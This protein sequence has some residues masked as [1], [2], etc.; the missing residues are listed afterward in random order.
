MSDLISLPRS[1]QTRFDFSYPFRQGLLFVRRQGEFWDA[2]GKG[3]Q[4]FWKDEDWKRAVESEYMNAPFNP[5]T[6]K[7]TKWTGGNMAQRE[8]LFY[9]RLIDK[10]PAP[11]RKVFDASEEAATIFI[12]KL[13][14]DVTNNVA[15]KW[16]RE[17]LSPTDP[18]FIQDLN[19]FGNYV[20]RATGYGNLGDLEKSVGLLNTV[21][22]GARRNISMVQAPGYLFN[23][24]AR[25]RVEAWKDFMGLFGMGAST[26]ALAKL[27]GIGDVNTF[28]PDSADWGKLKIGN[29]RLDIWGGYQQLARTVYKMADGEYKNGPNFQDF[30]KNALPF[31]GNKLSPQAGAAVSTLPEGVRRPI[32]PVDR[33]FK[34][35]D[36]LA[37]LAWQGLVQAVKEDGAVAGAIAATGIVGMGSQ[38]YES[39]TDVRNKEA[40]AQF[41]T[42]YENLTPVQRQQVDKSDAVTKYQQ[43]NPS[44]YKETKDRLLAPINQAEQQAEQAFKEGKLS[45]PLP[46]IW[47]EQSI[48]RQQVARDLADQFKDMFSNFD[49]TRYDKAVEGYYGKQVT[50][51][52]GTIDYDATEAAR[53]DYIKTLKPDE[54]Q[55]LDEALQVSRESKSPA[56]QKYLKYIDERKAAGYFDVKP[57][58]PDRAKKLVELDRKN[59][60]QDA[61]NWYWKGGTTDTNRVP[62]LNSPDAVSLAL[63]MA[64]DR[65]VTYA[66]LGRPLNQTPQV[67][68]AWNDYGPRI[69]NYYTKTVPAYQEQEAQ[70]LFNTSYAKLDRAQR[71]RVASSILTQVR[72][73]SP[74]LEAILQ[75]LGDTADGN[76]DY[77]VSAE[78]KPYLERMIAKYGAQPVKS[79]NASGRPSKFLVRQ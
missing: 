79:V 33:P 36:A 72:R 26:L 60:L 75:Y 76:G 20:N 21:F 2:F 13:R 9:N 25:V 57:D 61:L 65:P 14:S 29:T 46:D 19:I 7:L 62:A 34:L 73:G 71:E 37:P 30:W 78:A 51:P 50:N 32:Q 49:K 67:L 56:H 66:G 4:S 41:K 38:T 53:Q 64:P 74:E 42:D 52:D 3:L 58:D 59:P 8:E 31:L 16:I 68:Q 11:M 63:Q 22:Y 23:S 18:E 70:N 5:Q 45:K 55:W 24:S 17:G 69:Q 44:Q 43:E 27:A 6:L 47:H 28:N 35:T 10:F 1:L 54:Q 40:Q 12:N 39:Q 48:Q 77:V 15:R